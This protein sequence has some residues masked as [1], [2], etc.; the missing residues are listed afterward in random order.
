MI[1]F[2]KRLT[3]AYE[4]IK[5]LH[6]GTTRVNLNDDDGSL[7]RLIRGIVRMNIKEVE[8]SAITLPLSKVCAIAGYFPAN[9]Y[10]VD[11]TNLGIILR[12]RRAKSITDSFINT[13]QDYYDDPINIEQLSLLLAHTS[14]QPQNYEAKYRNIESLL[15]TKPVEEELVL[16]AKKNSQTINEALMGMGL[17]K[18]SKLKARAIIA[19]LIYCSMQTFIKLGE[20]SLIDVMKT[21]TIDQAARSLNHLLE[22]A[23]N[24][25]LTG[26][27]KV[28]R[29]IESTYGSPSQ[30]KI[31]AFWSI[32]SENSKRV[33]NN[34]LG[35]LVISEFFEGERA[36][37]WKSYV[38]NLIEW[39]VDR[40]NKRLILDFGSVVVV[41]FQETGNAAFLLS[42]ELYKREFEF[43][44]KRKVNHAIFKR[45]LLDSN[46]IGKIIHTS[47]WQNRT[48]AR[49]RDFIH[50]N[51]VKSRWQ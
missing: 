43:Q 42:P 20:D 26:F 14:D 33:F 36:D 34:W 49:M 10:K 4:M 3:E 37:F 45:K 38:D 11:R 32:L 16:Y 41:E 31:N 48:Q 25:E 35:K 24:V 50:R 18:E 13:W 21:M 9:T 28:A 44:V 46:Y 29:Y 17:R 39:F 6:P 27:T 15:G 40:E 22:I 12:I 23:N 8:D 7:E 5:K 30:R 47:Y 19:Q 51:E 1:F 2:P